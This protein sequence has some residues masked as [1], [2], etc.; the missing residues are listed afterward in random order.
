MRDSRRTG[1]ASALPPRGKERTGNGEENKSGEAEAR[2]GIEGLAYRYTFSRQKRIVEAL[3][4]IAVE[5]IAIAP[6]LGHRLGLPSR[7]SVH[8]VLTSMQVE[9]LLDSRILRSALGSLRVFRLTERGK[10]LACAL[11]AEPCENDWERLLRL[12]NGDKQEAHTALTLYAAYQ[13]RLRGWKAEVVPFDP[14]K[15]PWFQPDLKLTDLEG[16]VYYG[17]VETRSRAKPEKWA[18]RREVNLIVAMPVTRQWSVA[19]LKEAGI[20]GRATDLQSLLRRAK[21]GDLAQFWLEKW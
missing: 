1:H 13:A 12:H 3:R 15:T 10:S 20:P 16:R 14:I 4:V 2:K 19:R 5:G 6:E 7:L 18:Y 11:G 8:R 9:G 21:A 17:E